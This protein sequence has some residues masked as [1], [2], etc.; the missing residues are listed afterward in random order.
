MSDLAGPTW[1]AV[2]RYLYEVV[3]QAGP[4]VSQDGDATLARLSR[5]TFADTPGDAAALAV[6]LKRLG[7]T[8]YDVR[9]YLTLAQQGPLVGSELARLSDVPQ[10]RIYQI[11]GRLVELRLVEKEGQHGGVYRSTG[12][13]AVRRLAE[14]RKAEVLQ[15]A[16]E[17]DDLV[18]QTLPILA[19][20]SQTGDM[21][22]LAF[23]ETLVGPEQY[24]LAHHELQTGLRE[25][26]LSFTKPPFVLP[27]TSG[28]NGISSL[29]RGVTVRAI[30]E[31]PAPGPVDAAHAEALRLGLTEWLDAGEE[32]R[33]ID[34]LPMKMLVFDRKAAIVLL[35]DPRN[36]AMPASG[37]L[38]R[39]EAFA[40]ALARLFEAYWQEASR[41]TKAARA[42]VLD[43]LR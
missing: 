2:P 10:K 25:E 1:G 29:A 39:H 9:A 36:A 34:E 33:L 30:Y 6:T 28:Q 35:P 16:E 20:I 32:I 5:S 8:E 18:E 40:A 17:L 31:L 37:L 14:G 3:A 19:A 22:P 7:L 38:V 27:A 11:L 4:Q 24:R 43:S 12:A 42:R 41:V 13:S 21:R 26:L 15:V 23:V